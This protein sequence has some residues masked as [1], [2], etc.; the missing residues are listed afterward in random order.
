[1]ASGTTPPPAAARPS[2]SSGRLK[3]PFFHLL[4]IARALGGSISPTN[5]AAWSFS[6][7]GQ[8][9]LAP[10]SVFGF[11]SPLFRAPQLALAGPEFQIYTP[12]EASLRG[13]FIWEL[14][15]NPGVDFPGVNIT[16]FVSLGGDIP[17][18]IN[19]C[20]QTFLYGRMSPAMRQSLA[21]AIAAQQ[22]NNNRALTALYLTLLSGQHAVQH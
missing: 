17:A 10:P 20:D 4:S 9:P 18:L 8:T 21:T 5:Q 7:T 13:N 19:A 15:T 16:R 3:D 22:D 6:R 14:L 1:M 2:A 12:T 11:Y